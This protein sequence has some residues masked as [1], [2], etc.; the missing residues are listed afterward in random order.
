MTTYNTIYNIAYKNIDEHINV[1]YTP[2]NTAFDLLVKML[3]IDLYNFDNKFHNYYYD[4]F[5]SNNFL[6]H[7]QNTLAFSKQAHILD[8]VWF[9]DRPPLKFKKE[10]IALVRNQLQFTRKIFASND[11][12]ASWGYDSTQHSIIEYGLPIKPEYENIPKTESV[13]VINFNNNNEINNF[14]EHIKS[15]NTSAQIISGLKH[16]TSIDMLYEIMSKYKVVIDIYNPLTTLI[17]AYL[18]C[19]TI[20]A[21]NQPISIKGVTRLLDY[22]S[23]NNVLPSV[24]DDNLSDED[25]VNNQQWIKQNHNFEQFESTTTNLLTQIKNEEFFVS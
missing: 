20:T 25:I 9:H 15:S 5:W 13:L 22:S 4:L 10:D 17:A 11:T 7:T 21:T 8:L 14:Y 2:T 18:G 23:I 24:L 12:A 16:I 19:K 3:D 6:S 1:L